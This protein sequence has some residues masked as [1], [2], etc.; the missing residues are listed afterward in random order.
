M[1]EDVRD[2]QPLSRT[3]ISICNVMAQTVFSVL[4]MAQ[5][6]SKVPF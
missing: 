1:R 4:H 2:W 3:D 6:K 5:K